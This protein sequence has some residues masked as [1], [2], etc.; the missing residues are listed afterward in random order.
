M[1]HATPAPGYRDRWKPWVELLNLMVRLAPTG[2]KHYGASILFRR[3]TDGAGVVV[4][5]PYTWKLAGPDEI[6]YMDR[7][8]EATSSTAYARRAA[9]GDR[10][11]CLLHDDELVGYQWVRFRACC[12][13]CGFGGSMELT[14][15]PLAPNQAFFYDLYTYT[16]HRQRGVAKILRHVAYQGLMQLGI[17]EA[18]SLVDPQNLPALRLRATMDERPDRLV[19]G[20]RLRG[21][22]RTFLG[23]R[24]DARLLAWWDDFRAACRR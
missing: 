8:P 20:Y 10:C 9:H 4:P 22:Q 17:E 12:A 13:L 19:Y 1:T 11:I 16:A 3:R 24:D 23:P 7:H 5:A 15:L 14:F 2:R 18:L 21:W 6:D